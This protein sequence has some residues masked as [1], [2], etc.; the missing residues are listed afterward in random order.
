MNLICI[1]CECYGSLF[2]YNRLHKHL[3]TI[4][5]QFSKKILIGSCTIKS[6][7]DSTY[8]LQRFLKKNYT[9]VDSSHFQLVQEAMV[10]VVRAGTAR[11]AYHKDIVICGKTGTAQNP[12][13]KDHS[14]FI[15][16]A[17]KDDPKIAI[18]VYVENAGYGGTWAAPI[19]SL[20]IEKHLR[21]STSRPHLEKYVLEGNLIKK[22]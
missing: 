17:P 12:H 9:T 8:K 13:G 21:D 1:R 14:V 20:M 5:K 4:E 18:A 3:E 16:F 2:L 15:A 10:D 19:A 6:I 7:G 11:R 22:K